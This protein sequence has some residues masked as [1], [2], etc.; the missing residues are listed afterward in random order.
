MVAVTTEPKSYI[1]AVN[2]P[3]NSQIVAKENTTICYK[4]IEEVQFGPRHVLQE[5][6]NVTS[7][8]HKKG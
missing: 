6:E 8:E 1:V 5:N 7:N 3:F 4:E 2:D